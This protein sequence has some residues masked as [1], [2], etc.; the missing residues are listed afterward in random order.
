[1]SSENKSSSSVVI[2][3]PPGGI[4]E[5]TAVESAKLG[6]SVRWFVVSSSSSSNKVSFSEDSLSAITSAGGKVDLAGSR[7]EDLLIR[8]DEPSSAIPAVSSWCGQSDAII[9]CMDATGS[10]FENMDAEEVQILEDAIKVATK[11]VCKN[12]R[13]TKVAVSSLADLELDMENEGDGEGANPVTQAFSSL[14]GG[15]KAEVPSSLLSAMGKKTIRLRHGELFGL[16]ESSVCNYFHM[17]TIALFS[18]I[19]SLLTPS[20][21]GT[22]MK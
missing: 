20:F 13:G 9:S 2:I 21:L 8:A 3:S 14:L 15:N 10:A 6:A 7:A 11:E 1:M 12:A 19:F 16:P 4:G 22:D 17:Q 18:F 5:V